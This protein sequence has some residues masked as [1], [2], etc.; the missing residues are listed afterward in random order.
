MSLKKNL[1]L[2]AAP[3]ALAVGLGAAN[4]ANA[5]TTL[6]GGGQ[7]PVTCTQGC[8]PV[9]I[10]PPTTPTPPVVNNGGNGTGVGVGVGVGIGQGGAGGNAT[11]GNA[12]GG[13]VNIAPGGIQGGA[14]GQ[15]GQGGAGG[16]GGQGGI[17]QGGQGGIG[18]GGA[19][20]NA[21]VNIGDT[22]VRGGDQSQTTDVRNDNR[23]SATGGNIESGAMSNNVSYNSSYRAAASTAV[24]NASTF[25]VCSQGWGAGL[26]LMT[27]GASISRTSTTDEKCLT[28]RENAAYRLELVRTGN[29]DAMAISVTAQAE[30]DPSL[31]VALGADTS[32]LANR[33]R[34]PAQ[35]VQQPAPP[36]VVVVDRSGQA[37][38]APMVGGGYEAA[39]RV[40]PVLPAPGRN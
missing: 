15:G 13:S 4:D 27:A 28:N 10:D 31:A 21:D 7:P 11:G 37:P 23:S 25:G 6:P 33:F 24:S 39:G 17:C 18:Q 38:V 34:G 32:G 40:P 19:G 5:Q 3:F 36:S 30:K 12:T 35:P 22:N 1:A 26:Q 29:P 14:G 16:Q 2:A 9:I 20:G 8:G